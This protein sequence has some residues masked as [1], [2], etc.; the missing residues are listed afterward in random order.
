MSAR[1]AP[2]CPFPDANFR[3]GVPCAEV[4]R[5]PR[6]VIVPRVPNPGI[7]H[8]P[9]GQ[10]WSVI[11]A[12]HT[13]LELRREIERP[14]HRTRIVL[15]RNSATWQL[16]EFETFEPWPWSRFKL[17]SDIVQHTSVGMEVDRSAWSRSC[18]DK[19]QHHEGESGQ[20]GTGRSDHASSMR[21]H[22]FHE[23]GAHAAGP[24]RFDCQKLL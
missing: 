23:P 19:I 4:N 7:W 22:T 10:S 14:N 3:G 5:R 17:H 24:T 21:P 1:V 16:P 9:G 18:H 6:R 8:G 15:Y 12:T 11:R 2:V 20:A 13:D